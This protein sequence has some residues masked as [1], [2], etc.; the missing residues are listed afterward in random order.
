MERKGVKNMKKQN[1]QKKNDNHPKRVSNFQDRSNNKR[2]EQAKVNGGVFVYSKPLSV[3]DLS[4]AINIPVPSIIKFLFLQG[5]AVTINQVLDDE[6]I[7]TI[8]LEFNYDFRKEEAVDAAHFED[9]EMKDDPAD[10][11]P[12]PAVVT[13]MGHVDHGKTTLIDAIRSSHIVD[14]EAGGISQEIGAYQKEV[15]GQKIT[16]IDTPGHAAFTAMRARGASVTD[17]VVLVVAAD[18]GVMPQTLE[19]IDH[20]KAAGS[21]IIVAINKMDKAGAN[22][23]KVKEQ[24]MAHDVIAEDYGGDVMTCEISAKKGAGIDN[25]LDM[26]LLKAEMME[27]KANPKRYASGTVLEASLDKGE[28]PKATLLVQ[29]GTLTNS[30]YVVVGEIYG[31][32]RRMTNEYKKILKS[33]GPSC[34]VSV[35]G[36]SGVPSAGDRFMAFPTE[37]EAKEIAAKRA[38]EKQQN[39][40]AGNAAMS[41]DDLNN[42]INAGKV[43]D[44]NVLVKADTDGTAEALKAN[45]EKL[46]NDNVKVH[47]LSASSGAISDS[48]VLLAE[49]SHAIIF[50]FNVRPDAR[51]KQ[52]AEEAHVEIRLHKIIYELLDEMEAAM[53]GMI[54][55]EKVES[56]TG[57]AEIRHIFKIT[58][59]GTVAGSYVTDGELKVKSKARLIRDGVVIYDG[60]IA[61]LQH[62]KDAVKDIKAG[63][64]CGLTIAGYN[65]LKVGDIVEGYEMVEKK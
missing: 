56:V 6:T 18:D 65:D 7:G 8:C 14:T 28:G 13:I 35:I 34:P 36:L 41:L 4:K 19:A 50:G 42:L 61:S 62:G 31:K 29:N 52:K 9:I 15:H 37:K 32:V 12:R 47:V 3:A 21:P 45:L 48:D 59:V 27:L 30:D 40:R 26:I 58:H 49:A 64:E 60:E 10:L 24:L 20:A 38:L 16:F 54:S 51:V 53:K 43:K 57:Q 5:K 17:L 63:Y 11:E 33:A 25:L 1:F 55:V 39:T 46:S 2:T 22:P 44:L 23:R